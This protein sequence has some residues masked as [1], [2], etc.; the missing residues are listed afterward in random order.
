MNYHT[1]TIIWLSLEPYYNRGLKP[2]RA[3][4]IIEK[5]LDFPDSLEHQGINGNWN[6]RTLRT[7]REDIDLLVLDIE[8]ALSTELS[9]SLTNHK[10]PATL[11]I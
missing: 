4:E 6:V 2:E 7:R 11:S 9:D 10:Q 8:Y 1:S 3:K 5:V